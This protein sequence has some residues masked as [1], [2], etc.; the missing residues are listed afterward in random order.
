MISN[1]TGIST[2]PCLP[3]ATNYDDEKL[4]RRKLGAHARS[5]VVVREGDTETVSAPGRRHLSVND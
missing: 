2:R 1:P 5:T 3:L 4:L